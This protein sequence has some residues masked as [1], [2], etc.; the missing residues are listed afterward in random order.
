[1]DL[2]ASACISLA[3]ISLSL[4]FLRTPRAPIRLRHLIAGQLARHGRRLQQARIPGRPHSFFAMT[5]GVPVLLFIVGWLQSPVLA[6]LAGASGLLVPRLYLAWLVHAQARRSEGEA[7]RL[8]Q[9]LLTSLTAGSTYLDALRQARLATTDPWIREDLDFVIQRFLLDVPLHDSMRELRARVAT[10]NLALVWE[11][12]IICSANQLPTQAA[13]TL[14][15]ELS[16]TVQFNVQLASEVRAKTSGQRLQ[17]WLLAII[18]PGMYLY[19]RLISP[20]LLQA[21]DQT[22]MGRYVLVPAAALLEMLGIYL[23]F[24]IARFEA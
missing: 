24:R 20:E 14:F 9:A 4:A 5:V 11:T 18:V 1:M 15:Y 13:R 3:I 17:I 16:V 2:V 23:S 19:L 10:R 12:L 8:L 7:P 22:V 21:L 6:I